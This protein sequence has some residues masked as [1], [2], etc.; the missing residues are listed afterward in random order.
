MVITE[1]LEKNPGWKAKILAT[2]IDTNMLRRGRAGVYRLEDMKTIPDEYHKY[3][4]TNSQKGEER[5]VMKEKLRNLIT[6]NPLNLL[7]QEWPMKQQ[8]DFLFC[9]N[10]VIY[11]DKPTQST[12]FSR[13]HKQM[14]ER[15]WLFIGHSESLHN[16]STDFKIIG[17]TVYERV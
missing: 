2:D 13:Y 15:S 16:V 10:V 8:F 7:A 3:I 5:I 11:F 12:L 4:D 17:R 6:F 14:K 1:F 9:R